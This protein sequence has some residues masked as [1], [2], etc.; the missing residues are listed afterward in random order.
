MI[1]STE[2][3]A[4]MGDLSAPMPSLMLL[5]IL[6]GSALLLLFVVTVALLSGARRR[7]GF[8]EQQLIEIGADLRTISLR[9]AANERPPSRPEQHIDQPAA[10]E[11][12]PAEVLSAVNKDQRPEISPHMSAPS[13]AKPNRPGYIH[14]NVKGTEVPS[15]QDWAD[16]ADTPSGVTPSDIL[17]QTH[18][19]P[20]IAAHSPSETPSDNPLAPMAGD[21]G[22]I[23]RLRAVPKTGHAP[24]PGRDTLPSEG[25]RSGDP[26]REPTLRWPPKSS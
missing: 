21:E 9:M 18:F 24:P 4:A 25:S 5:P 6:F 26:R 7:L 2:G 8:I 22:D 20:P 17:K 13:T 23:W 11:V 15:S 19:D 14:H 3:L 16:Y 1:E 10:L 12:S